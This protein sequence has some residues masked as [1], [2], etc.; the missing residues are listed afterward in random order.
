MK[1]QKSRYEFH[2]KLF[3]DIVL[4][5][6][7][8][9]QKNQLKS[10]TKFI[11]E[12]N[13]RT[14]FFQLQALARIDSKISKHIELAEKWAF[15]FKEIEDAF[16][17]YDFWAILL[18]KNKMWGFSNE[19]NSFLNEQAFSALGKLEE[20]LIK[21]GWFIKNSAGLPITEP[22]EQH[23]SLYNISDTPILRFEKSVQKIDWQSP[24]KEQKKLLEFLRDYSLKIHKKI[25]NKEINLNELELGIHEFRR[26]IRWISI[27]ASA[28]RGKITLGKPLDDLPLNEYVTPNRIKIPFNKLPEN[29]LE[30]N[31]V[32]FLPGGFYALGELIKK[33]GDIK[34]PGLYTEEM[35]RLGKLFGL[36]Q[37]KIKKH[38]GADYVTHKDVVKSAQNLVEK[39]V[40]KEKVLLHIANYFDQQLK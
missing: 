35:T 23:S 7:T 34:D 29:D 9:Q 1:T 28:L 12:N 26:K 24:K 15:E 18:D 6:L 2:L 22:H 25:E 30:K 38:L 20:R 3:K 31:L 39:Y 21:S 10:P 8:Q 14:P 36:S 16:G 11:Y 4:K 32:D 37:T 5:S 27:Y 33:L 13:G 17:Q 40:I 19:I